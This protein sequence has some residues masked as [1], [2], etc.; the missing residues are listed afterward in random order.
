MNKKALLIGIGVLSVGAIGYYFWMNRKKEEVTSI[1]EK[2]EEKVVFDAS[3][4]QQDLVNA[5][6]QVNLGVDRTQRGSSVINNNIRGGGV[7]EK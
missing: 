5:V 2:N 7:Y 4:K 1:D 3:K 6:K